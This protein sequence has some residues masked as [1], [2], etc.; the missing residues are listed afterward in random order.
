VNAANT[1]ARWSVTPAIGVISTSGLYTPPTS[2]GAGATVTVTATSFADPTKQATATVNLLASA[3]PA[4]SLVATANAQHLSI[5]QNTWV[6]IK[7]SNLAPDTRIWQST[8]FVNGQLPT[9]LDGV[10]VTVDGKPAFVYYISPTQVNVLTPIDSNTGSVPVQLTNS[11]AS[12]TPMTA[13]MQTDSPEFFVINGGPYVV[14]THADGSDLGPTSLYPGVTTPAARGEV[15]VLYGNGFGQTSPAIVNGSVSQSGT[16]PALPVVTIGGINSIV[17]FA[18]VISPG[19]FQVNVVVPASAPR[20]DN[21]LV[22]T[23]NGFSTQ[24]NILITLN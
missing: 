15:V 8:D 18:G 17:Q 21:P 16:L 19:L 24:A 22:A 13:L 9:E 7:G 4:V 12:A 5:A 14:G 2:S 20:G 11:G 6:E 23:Y 1:N 10:S 3:G